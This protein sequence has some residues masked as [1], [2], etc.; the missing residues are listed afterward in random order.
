M[1]LRMKGD[2]RG[3]YMS[4]RDRWTGGVEFSEGITIDNDIYVLLINDISIPQNI[5]LKKENN[6]D[7]IFKI[8]EWIII[9]LSIEF[10]VFKLKD[11]S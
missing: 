8:Y 6:E 4:H 3:I 9:L 5:E 2:I 7:L 10:S 1:I 11:K